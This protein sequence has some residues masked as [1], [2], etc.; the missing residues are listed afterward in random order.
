MVNDKGTRMIQIGIEPRRLI[1][2]MQSNAISEVV[3]NI[4]AYEGVNILV[5]ES[6][7]GEILGATVNL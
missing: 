6:E 4:P 2:E 5:A 1:E 7:T 3:N